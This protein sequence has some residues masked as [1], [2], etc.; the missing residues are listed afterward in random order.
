MVLILLGN[1]YW[2]ANMVC[3]LS[4]YSTL[5]VYSM[6]YFIKERLVDNVFLC[7]M[8]RELVKKRNASVLFQNTICMMCMSAGDFQVQML[9]LLV[10]T[11][12]LISLVKQH[13]LVTAATSAPLYTDP[14]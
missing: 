11:K 7:S 3:T 1:I 9:L 13:L 6:Q 8:V 5:N 2:L 14:W 12:L 4:Y 10:G